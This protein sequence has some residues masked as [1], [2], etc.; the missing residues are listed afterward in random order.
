MVIGEAA[1]PDDWR[2]TAL[3]ALLEQTFPDPDSVLGLDRMRQFLAEKS[4]ERV[5]K[6]LVAEDSLGRVVGGSVFSYVPRSNCGFSEY[7]VLEPPLRGRGLGREVFDRRREIL[8]RLAQQHGYVRCRGLFIEVDNPER[9]P[10]ELL[11]AERKSSLDAYER[12]RLFGHLGFR[13]VD[14]PY[15]QPPLGP[16][17]QTVEYLDLLFGAWETGLGVLPVDW[18]LQTLEPIWSAWAPAGAAGHLAQLRERI[19]S[20]RLVSLDAIG[21]EA[22]E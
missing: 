21:G 11:A 2:L 18:I 9:T 22:A 14:V 16:G 1:R 12:L 5:F 6:V 10:P 17:K 4:G 7:L 20:A 13:K 19:G 3:A 15:V 8:D